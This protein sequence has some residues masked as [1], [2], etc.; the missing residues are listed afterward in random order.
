MRNFFINQNGATTGFRS[1]LNFYYSK[2]PWCMVYEKIKLNF[3]IDSTLLRTHMVVKFQPRGYKN[4]LT[5]ANKW[6]VSKDHLNL[7]KT[8]E[9]KTT[10]NNKQWL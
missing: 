10:S 9:R 5:S 7:L 1:D 3:N 2:L 8:M 6:T 4:I